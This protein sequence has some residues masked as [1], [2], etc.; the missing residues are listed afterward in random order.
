MK[1]SLQEQARHHYKIAI[2]Q[3]WTIVW[4]ELLLFNISTPTSTSAFTL[5]V[6][7]PLIYPVQSMQNK[8]ECFA[9]SVGLCQLFKEP[10]HSRHS[11]HKFFVLRQGQ[12]LNSPTNA[13]GWG[14]M[15]QLKLHLSDSPNMGIQNKTA[16][17]KQHAHS[18]VIVKQYNIMST[19]VY[20][21]WL[22]CQGRNRDS[23]E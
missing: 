10:L 19:Q 6:Y 16:N 13:F 9:W 1:I 12:Q 11:E 14:F 7:N 8:Q 23:W 4:A 17:R 21:L 20:C 5:Q 3:H 2:K 15:K 18:D 22:S